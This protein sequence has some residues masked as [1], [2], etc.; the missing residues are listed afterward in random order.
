MGHKPRRRWLAVSLLVILAAGCGN[1]SGSRCPPLD[2]QERARLRSYVQKKYELAVLPHLAETNVVDA[3]CY[4]A[5]EFTAQGRRQPFRLE[6]YLSPDLRYLSTELLDSSLDPVEEERRQEEA[7]MAGLA[8]GHHATAGRPD[9]PVTLT[10]FSDFQCS[11]CSEAARMLITEILPAESASV[12][13][14]FR[15]FPL[16][17]HDWAQRAAEATACAQRQSNDH[18]WSLHDFIFE[19]QD[20]LTGGNLDQKLADYTARLAQFDQV[21]HRSCLE[22]RA[23]RE[24]VAQD[25]AF[26]KANGVSGTPTL[27]VN[28]HLLKGAGSPVQIKTLIRELSQR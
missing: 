12:R 27:F 4:R 16:G 18:F 24:Q 22:D 2:E 17:F 10:L 8:G 15:H 26:A 13:L 3:T 14:V 5:L 21:A 6:L 1:V 7:L 11:Y 19:H 9:A 23:A 20:E 28:P 25:I